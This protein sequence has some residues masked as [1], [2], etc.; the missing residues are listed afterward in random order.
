MTDKKSRQKRSLFWKIPSEELQNLLNTHNTYKEILDALN[1]RASCGNYKTLNLVIKF[2]ELDLTNINENRHKK[3]I[4][5]GKKIRKTDEEIFVTSSTFNNRFFIKNR[6]LERGWDYRC[7]ECN[8][9]NTYNS[10]PISLQLD[11]INGIHN[12]NR[13]KNLRFLCP[14]CHSQTITFSGKKSRRLLH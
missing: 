4:E 11:H 10:K 2:Y 1:V 7:A 12:D 9:T 3:M 8:I 6:L 5:T 14:N 13:L